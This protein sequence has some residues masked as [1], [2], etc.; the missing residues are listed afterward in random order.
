MITTQHN[1]KLPKIDGIQVRA[2]DLAYDLPALVD[3]LNI[4][5]EFEQTEE[6]SSVEEVRHIYQ[7]AVNC[8][9]TTDFVVVEVKGEL[10]AFQR[11]S[12][13]E[14]PLENSVMYVMTGSVHPD[15]HDQGIGTALGDWAENRLREIS[16]SHAADK[17]KYLHSSTWKSAAHRMRFLAD[18]GFNPER[19]FY[20]M[21]RKDLRDLPTVDLP[22]GI[23]LRQPVSETDWRKG[24]ACLNDAFKDHWGYMPETE[25]DFQRL[26]HN[27]FTRSDLTQFAWDGDTVI[28]TLIVY[29][30]EESNRKTHKKQA[31]TED[32]SVLK[33]YRGQGI[34][35]AMIFS[36]M[37]AVKQAG[38]ESA[39]LGVDT[40]N[41]SGALRLYEN[42]GYE[43]IRT[44]ISFRKPL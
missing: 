33:S 38:M 29:I 31:W 4:V 27:P 35:K 44:S 8:N 14:L 5:T 39:M 40:N 30:N 1:I 20:I 15:W 24:A 12:W 26:L 17:K 36:A 43:A 10:V 18:R 2:F 34:A 16:A 22:A 13:R 11:V 6:Y 28:G 23:V 32:I 41:P 3:L 9:F 42:C 25:A 19:Y 37:H 21:E 7:H